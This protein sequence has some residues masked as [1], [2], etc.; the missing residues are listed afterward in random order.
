[1]T[2]ANPCATNNGGCHSKRTCT[3]N[4]GSAKCGDCPDG[5]TN[6][7]AKGCKTAPPAARLLSCYL[8]YH[9]SVVGEDG[10]L[11]ATGDNPNGQFGNGN[12][13]GSTI[14]IPVL[15]NVTMAD[16]YRHTVALKKDGSV[17]AAGY[18]NRGQLGDGTNTDR[19]SFVEVIE[20]G[21]VK[22]Y[23]GIFNTV[24]LKADGS[25]WGT[26]KND[27]GDFGTGTNSDKNKFVKVIDGVKDMFAKGETTFVLKADGSL[28]ATGYNQKLSLIH[29]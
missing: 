16:G 28:W 14:F 18:N 17:W 23:T 25:V 22:M 6:D 8:R 27:F 2:I 3:N 29:I 11:Y 26:G 4:A 12:T 19:K 20:K 24:V 9:T 7:G 1:M 5:L 13:V 10:T 15:S 21:V